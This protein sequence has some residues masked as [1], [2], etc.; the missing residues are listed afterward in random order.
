M[1]QRVTAVVLL[2]YTLFIVGFLLLNPDVDFQQWQALF[3]N[4]AMRIFTLLLVFSFAAHAWI[5]LWC[6]TT[7]Y[8]PMTGL[9]FLVQAGTGLMTFIY[10]AWAIHIIWGV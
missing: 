8:I 6:V 9:R 5:G 7:D 1:I 2:A 4:T 10:V 3:A